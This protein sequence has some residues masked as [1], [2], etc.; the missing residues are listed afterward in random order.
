[1][2]AGRSGSLK[3]VVTVRIPSWAEQGPDKRGHRFERPGQPD[4]DMREK[5]VKE[6][7]LHL[8]AELVPLTP[9]RRPALVRFTGLHLCRGGHFLSFPVVI[10]HFRR[11][12][13]AQASD[14]QHS[15]ENKRCLLF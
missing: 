4:G 1:M 15:S 2:G 10:F 14:I 11:I 7:L 13:A 9:P 5:R 3:G 6:P 12:A 8:P